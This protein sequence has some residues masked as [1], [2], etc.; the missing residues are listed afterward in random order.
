MSDSISAPAVAARWRELVWE[1]MTY[2][3]YSADEI[4]AAERFK[5]SAAT[6]EWDPNS[7]R[8]DCGDENGQP[9]HPV[10]DEFAVVAGVIER[11]LDALSGPRG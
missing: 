4:R 1:E 6:C 5:C 10:A 11:V 2:R 8:W 3:G 7:L 9:V